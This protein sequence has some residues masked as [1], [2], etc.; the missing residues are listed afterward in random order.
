MFSLLP[1]A[2]SNAGMSSSKTEVSATEEI[3]PRAARA[4]SSG[5]SSEL[6]RICLRRIGDTVAIPV[7]RKI[8]AC[9]PRQDMHMDMRHCLAREYTVCLYQAQSAWLQ[10]VVH[11]ASQFGDSCANGSKTFG[12]HLEHG[13]KVGLR[14]YE[15][16]ALISGMDV[17]EGDGGLVAIEFL[18][19]RGSGN[20]LAKDA[21][22]SGQGVLRYWANVSLVLLIQP[23]L[24]AAYQVY[25]LPG[26]RGFE[27]ANVV[28]A[29]WL[30]YLPNSRGV[31][32]VV[33]PFSG[34]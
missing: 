11:R 34:S 5:H 16:M 13:G 21:L 10:R 8:V 17:H 18:T 1:E 22:R 23:G 29:S 4:D 25:S 26:V 14:D 2:F 12:R 32:N 33:G 27:P 9:P 19:L 30:K 24:K 7:D 3:I 20:D 6:D 15:A 28:L 31:P